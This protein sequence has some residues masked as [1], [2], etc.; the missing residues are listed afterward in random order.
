MLNWSQKAAEQGRTSADTAENGEKRTENLPRTDQIL[1]NE[2]VL[3]YVA[4]MGVTLVASAVGALGLGTLILLTVVVLNRRVTLN[5]VN[6]S[7]AQISDQLRE[8]Q[9]GPGAKQA[10]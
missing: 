6:A 3:T 7:L 10:L 2:V 4:S 9:A 8:L 1:R 5:Q